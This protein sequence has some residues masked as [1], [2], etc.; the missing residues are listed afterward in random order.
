MMHYLRLSSLLFFLFTTSCAGPYKHLQQDVT[1]N[2]SALRF[3]PEFTKEL[4]RCVVDGRI[5]FKKFHLSGLLFFKSMEDGTTRAVFQNEMGFTFFDFEW[6]TNDSFTVK[7][8]IAQLDK[9]ALVKTL[10]KDMNL[11]LM[12][13]LHTATEKVFKDGE[14]T[15][16]RFDLDNGTAYYITRK[17][18]LVR[19]ENA[20][21]SKVVTITVTGKATDKAMPAAVLFDHHKANF[22]IQLN[23][24]EANADE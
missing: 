19:I 24:I 21:K 22:T 16:C 5:V 13:N 12:R 1:N 7:Q 18:Q 23:R 2:N 9:P 17:D 14:E 4:Y 15:F 11:L 3:K 10:Q 6:S 8:I 20:G